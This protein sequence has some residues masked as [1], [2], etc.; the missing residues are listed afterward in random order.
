MV[1][2]PEVWLCVLVYNCEVTS[3]MLFGTCSLQVK[4]I[5]LLQ[6]AWAPVITRVKG[7]QSGQQYWS[8]WQVLLPLEVWLSSVSYSTGMKFGTFLLKAGRYLG[9]G[10]FMPISAYLMHPVCFISVACMWYW[11]ADANSCLDVWMCRRS[12][13]S[14]HGFVYVQLDSYSWLWWQQSCFVNSFFLYFMLVAATLFAQ[15]VR[16]KWCRYMCSNSVQYVKS[17][18]PTF[19]GK[20]IFLPPTANY[21]WKE[22]ISGKKRKTV[23]SFLRYHKW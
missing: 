21:L 8:V 10:E 2:I 5:A 12:Y 4:N 1:P 22:K 23:V 11:E 19:C 13:D 18:C 6:V 9:P 3:I 17:V 7:C 15:V 14:N 16:H 20:R